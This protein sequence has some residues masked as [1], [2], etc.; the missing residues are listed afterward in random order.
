MPGKSAERKA[1]SRITGRQAVSQSQKVSS[2]SDWAD[3][4]QSRPNKSNGSAHQRTCCCQPARGGGSG[5][6]DGSS[7]N[8]F[9]EI[10]MY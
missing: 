1:K 2:S 4:I 10:T 5:D 3:P 9:W 7:E 8:V 6:K